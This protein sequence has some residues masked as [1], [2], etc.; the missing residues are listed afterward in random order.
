VMEY[1][2]SNMFCE[3]GQVEAV[4]SFLMENIECENDLIRSANK[5]AQN[6]RDELVKY[7]KRYILA[8]RKMESIMENG[9]DLQDRFDMDDEEWRTP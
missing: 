5:G 9:P 1:Y 4:E 7:Q 8:N 6:S 3:P 2:L